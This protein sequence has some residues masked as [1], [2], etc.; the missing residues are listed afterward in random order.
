MKRLWSLS[1]TKT[2]PSRLSLL[3]SHQKKRKKSRKNK[4]ERLL[5][6]EKWY[7]SNFLLFSYLLY[8]C[9]SY[10][11]LIV[12][13]MLSFLIVTSWI[14]LFFLSPPRRR[15]RRQQWARQIELGRPRVHLLWR[16]VKQPRQT[17]VTRLAIDP[18]LRGSRS[19]EDRSVTATWQHLRVDSLPFKFPPRL[20]KTY[21]DK[22]ERKN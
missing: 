22:T 19:E 11:G 14:Y 8:L 9:V 4:R 17:C 18:P 16:C 5:L 21:C 10:L 7:L 12:F 20:A 6:L 3:A 13:L 1:L 2:Y 15:R